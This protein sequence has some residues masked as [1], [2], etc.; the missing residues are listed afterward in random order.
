V[1]SN[2]WIVLGGYA[3]PPTISAFGS[4]VVTADMTKNNAAA[5]VAGFIPVTPVVF[6]ATE[7]N[8]SPTNSNI[9]NGQANSTFTSTS[10]N[11]PTVCAIVDNETVCN[12]SI[13]L[14][15]P[16]TIQFGSAN[17]KEDE[18]Q[19]AIVHII[20]AGDTTASATVEFSAAPGAAPA[21]TGGTCAS[22]ADFV[23]VTNQLVSFGIGETDKPVNVTICPDAVTEVDENIALTLSNV[24]GATISS[25]T[26]SLAINDTASQTV[27]HTT[28]AIN[29]GQQ[30]SP[31]PSPI[32][33]T[34]LPATVGTM[35]VTLYDVWE[36]NP[37]NLDVL[38][39]GPNGAKYLL[40]ADTGGPLPMTPDQAVTLTF[41]DSALATVPD[42]G[43]WTTGQFLPT[44]CESAASNFPGTAPAG[45]YIEPGCLVA[46]P[47][48]STLFG[49]F[50]L[51]N[52]NGTWNL[53]IRDDNGSL[54]PVENRSP[55]AVVGEIAGG[56]GLEFLPLTAA[57]VSVSGRVLSSDG[58]GITNAVVTVTGNSLSQPISVVTGRYGRY[59]IPNLTAGSTY[60]VTVA[61]RR[62]EFSMPSRV[63]TLND[64]LADLDFVGNPGQ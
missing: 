5:T 23:P 56:W 53:Y 60:V 18:S 43:P 19:T 6:T 52:P 58:R 33:V 63:V 61:S 44:T 1:T 2:P 25:P 12:V 13:N 42:G 48:A 26:A 31:D 3:T 45:P 20:R 15:A 37:D 46:R 8:M 40:V 24:S 64:N 32:I 11:T 10:T 51:I 35:R 22:G 39:V 27:N 50:G 49:S 47:G 16:P 9:V 62:F 21:A 59:T 14:L 7:G 36:G 4:T 28:I 17:Y 55:E 54:R 30:G 41:K 57:D 29:L 34:G 38:L